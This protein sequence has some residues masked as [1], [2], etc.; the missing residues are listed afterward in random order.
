M[1][2]KIKS[3][4]IR[5]YSIKEKLHYLNENRPFREMKMFNQYFGKLKLRNEW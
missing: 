4:K 1:M 2:D 5:K 3:T